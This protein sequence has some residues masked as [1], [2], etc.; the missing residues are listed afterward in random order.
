M[1]DVRPVYTNRNML[2]NGDIIAL[3]N[4]SPMRQNQEFKPASKRIGVFS[5]RERP[6]PVSQQA[7]PAKNYNA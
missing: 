4:Q 2:N 7:R 1:K 3:S 6:E 5:P